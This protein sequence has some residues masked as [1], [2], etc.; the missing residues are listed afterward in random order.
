MLYMTN[1][2]EPD[3]AASLCIRCSCTGREPGRKCDSA[4]THRENEEVLD[5]QE[6]AERMGVSVDT[7]RRRLRA[8]ELP[9]AARETGSNAPWRIPLG[10]L[11]AAGLTPVASAAGGVPHATPTNSTGLDGHLAVLH[12]VVAILQ[13]QIRLLE[14]TDPGGPYA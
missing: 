10:D 4:M 5:I 1:G 2:I 11:I 13:R 8:G 14:T 6:A 3:G 12:E 9:R 7:I